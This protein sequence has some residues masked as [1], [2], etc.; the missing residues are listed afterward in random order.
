MSG[1]MSIRGG[2]V[3]LDGREEQSD[4]LGGEVSRKV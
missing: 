1:D 3:R 4:E 2:S